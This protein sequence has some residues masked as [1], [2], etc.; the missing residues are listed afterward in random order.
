MTNH[1]C[2]KHHLNKSGNLRNPGQLDGT[3]T[4]TMHP[5]FQDGKAEVDFIALRRLPG[6]AETSDS[7]FNRRFA[8]FLMH[9]PIVLHL[10]SGLGDVV[11]SF[12]G[13][14]FSLCQ[15]GHKAAFKG[16]PECFLLAV[17]IG[18]VRQGFIVL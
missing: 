15:H 10:D 18:A 14:Q 2:A 16:S 8:G 5:L 11:Q 1:F 13:D 17:L 3:I 6:N 9:L 4:A 12:Q 7:P